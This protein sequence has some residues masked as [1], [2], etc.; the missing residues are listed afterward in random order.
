M[1]TALPVAC[2]LTAADLPARVAEIGAIG[3]SSLLGAEASER[4]ALL[5]FR[6]DPRTR[7]RVAA[8]VAAEAECCAF[9]TMRVSVELGAIRV[10]IEAPAG[11]EAV[12]REL[13]RAFGGASTE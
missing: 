10:S 4:R 8:I 12:L 2:S 13:V 7:E 3:Q 11:A 9:L 5:R 1:A 6:D